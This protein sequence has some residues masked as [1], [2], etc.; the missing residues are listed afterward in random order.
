MTEH[1][2]PDI[3]VT[4]L[5]LPGDLHQRVN[6]AADSDR[7]SFNNEAIVLLVEALDARERV[8]QKVVR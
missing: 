2:P 8:G 7:R 3:K 6:S 4:T 5:R 1:S